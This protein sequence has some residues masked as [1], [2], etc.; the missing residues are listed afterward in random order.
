MYVRVFFTIKFPA[1]W[2]YLKLLSKRTFNIIIWIYISVVK[3]GNWNKTENHQFSF[4]LIWSLQ[5][6]T[7]QIWQQKL[8]FQENSAHF[9]CDYYTSHAL[10]WILYE[11]Q[12]QN[13]VHQ[14]IYVLSILLLAAW[15]T[16]LKYLINMALKKMD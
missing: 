15:S 11:K 5:N 10:F 7:K 1:N 2:Q 9:S 3:Q 6:Y 14:C 12:V 8:I 4:S 16:W 13:T